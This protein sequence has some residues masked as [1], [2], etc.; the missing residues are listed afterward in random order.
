MQVG[1]RRASTEEGVLI[2]QARSGVTAHLDTPATGA[3]PTLTSALRI[4][5][6][7]KERVLTTEDDSHVSV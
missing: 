3:R 5:V 4:R 2:L 6:K 1:C 7:T